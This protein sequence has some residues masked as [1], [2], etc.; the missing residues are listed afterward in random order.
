MRIEVFFLLSILTFLSFSQFPVIFRVYCADHT[1]CTL[2]F[3]LNTSAEG[4]KHVAA[5]KLGLKHDDLILVELKSSGKKKFSRK[6]FCL[7][8]LVRFHCA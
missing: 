6:T 5:D 2:R 7:L 8:C 4:L 1:Y 3:P